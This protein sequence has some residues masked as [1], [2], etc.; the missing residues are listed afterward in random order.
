MVTMAHIISEYREQL[1]LFVSLSLSKASRWTLLY[2]SKTSVS[3]ALNFRNE[4]HEGSAGAIRGAIGHLCSNIIYRM[5]T[6]AGAED[7]WVVGVGRVS[8][9]HCG[10][11]AT[12]VAADEVWTGRL[13]KG[14]VWLCSRGR[15]GGVKVYTVTSQKLPTSASIR[16]QVEGRGSGPFV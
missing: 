13:L 7:R 6:R 12:I 5:A 16:R 1:V 4:H 2:Q 3:S 15:W 14:S 8:L 9:C 11:P 10:P